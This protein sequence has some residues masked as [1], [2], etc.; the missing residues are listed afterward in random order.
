VESPAFLEWVRFSL[1][2][3]PWSRALNSWT[4]RRWR[5]PSQVSASLLYMVV[6]LTATKTCN[7]RFLR[8]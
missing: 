4:S 3:A 2:W 6:P 1:D 8:G 5:K 7:A